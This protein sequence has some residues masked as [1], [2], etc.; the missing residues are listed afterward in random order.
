MF[1]INILH[2]DIL[3]YNQYNNYNIVMLNTDSKVILRG[4]YELETF[5]YIFNGGNLSLTNNLLELFNN[6]I[7]EVKIYVDCEN[8]II[9]NNVKIKKENGVFIYNGKLIENKIIIENLPIHVT[10]FIFEYK[11]IDK[12]FKDN[13][14]FKQIT[15]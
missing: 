6:M 5:K 11:I 14:I 2:G 7:Y 15:K 9:C 10:K 1:D 3:K 4:K 12:N 8:N 13:T